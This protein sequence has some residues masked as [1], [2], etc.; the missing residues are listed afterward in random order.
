MGVVSLASMRSGETGQID[1]LYEGWHFAGRMAELGFC[2]GTKIKVISSDSY[3]PL[4]VEIK[5]CGRVAVG[6]GEAEKIMV[7]KSE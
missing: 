1:S 4:I 5:G 6:H 2:K 7:E 3:G